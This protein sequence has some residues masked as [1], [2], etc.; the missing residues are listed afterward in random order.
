M[1]IMDYWSAFSSSDIDNDNLLDA[2]ELKM[3][4]WVLRDDMPKEME[5][6]RERHAMDR[7]NNGTVDRIEW[8]AYLAAPRVQMN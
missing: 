5:V 7:D 2:R 1:R 8:V 4:I 3:L 6:L